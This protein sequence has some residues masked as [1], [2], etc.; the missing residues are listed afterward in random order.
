MDDAVARGQGRGDEPV[1][2]GRRRRILADR[3]R[4]LG[5]DRALDLSDIVLIRSRIGG[6]LDDV[7][8]LRSNPVS[9]WH[10]VAFAL[11]HPLQSSNRCAAVLP[12]P[13]RPSIRLQGGRR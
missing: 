8:A 7:C 3:K 4:Q 2:V 9:G 6:A 1:P 5:E 13:W 10:R 12:P 11:I